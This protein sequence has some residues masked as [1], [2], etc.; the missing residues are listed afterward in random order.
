MSTVIR[1]VLS[2]LA[3]LVLAY[4][5]VF[6]AGMLRSLGP[7]DADTADRLALGLWVVAPVMGGL[8]MR[9]TSDRQINIAAAVLGIVVG[10]AVAV[11]FLAAAGTA[12][13]SGACAGIPRS[14][15]GFVAGCVALGTVVA[16]GI[17]ACLIITA[18][19]TRRGWWLPGILGGGGLNAVVNVG[20]YALAYS[21]VGCMRP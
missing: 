3:V 19:L 10:V 7:L 14:A 18:R 5:V 15:G 17:G 4:L 2:P 1:G 16:I 13:L 6:Y 9:S 21:V 8:L 12:A 11:F 20:A